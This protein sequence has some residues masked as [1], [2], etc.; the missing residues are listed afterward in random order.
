M[1]VTNSGKTDDI[2]Q[3]VACFHTPLGKM[4]ITE[5]EKGITSL[6]FTE[7]ADDGDTAAAGRYLAEAA[8][9]IREYLAGERETFDVPLNPRGSAFQ[10]RVWN[11]LLD[12]PYGETRS[13]QQIAAAAGNPGAARAVGIAN[14]RNPI[15][16]LIPCHRVV[17]KNGMP[18]GYAAGIERKKYLLDLEAAR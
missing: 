8:A 1:S 7:D 4:R 13:Y 14:H 15:L 10:R 17:G 6:R 18:A 3:A 12:I 5:S 11:A 9:Q 2:E 16:I